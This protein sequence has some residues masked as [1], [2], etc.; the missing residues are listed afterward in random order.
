ML[1][2]KKKKKSDEFTNTCVKKLPLEP[3]KRFQIFFLP[4][5]NLMIKFV[6]LGVR[7][8]GL[9]LIVDRWVVKFGAVD[10]Y[11]G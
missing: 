11:G 7:S 6:G 9:F 1:W 8:W 10:G 3:C 2:K 5:Q 4:L